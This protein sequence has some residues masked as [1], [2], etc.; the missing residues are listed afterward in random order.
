MSRTDVED[1]LAHLQAVGL[2]VPPEKFEAVCVILSIKLGDFTSTN[3]I[4][5]FVKNLSIASNLE[6]AVAGIWSNSHKTNIDE[7]ANAWLASR[8]AGVR[9]PPQQDPPS[10]DGGE[11]LP[12][13]V[14][15]LAQFERAAH[16]LQ[17]LTAGGVKVVNSAELKRLIGVL[18]TTL[19]RRGPNAKRSD[20]DTAS[21][22][23]ASLEAD[24]LITIE[25]ARRKRALAILGS[26]LAVR[27]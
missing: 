2:V 18:A 16:V 7:A 19:A 13:D 3:Y 5:R 20:Y 6:I 4:H 11:E 25:P 17:M 14:Y 1:L 27:C 15:A 23:L 12:F 10:K 26:A 24:R 21:S 8:N 22:T 9:T